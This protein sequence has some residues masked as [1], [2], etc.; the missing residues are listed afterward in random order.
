[1]RHRVTKPKKKKLEELEFAEVLSDT[2]YKEL[3]YDQLAILIQNKTGGRKLGRPVARELFEAIIEMIF[4]Q[5]VGGGYFRFPLG[6]GALKVREFKGADK[7]KVM[8]TR[9][10]LPV[11]PIAQPGDRLHLRYTEGT[12][13][14]QALGTYSL[15]YKRKTE[16]RSRVDLSGVVVLDAPPV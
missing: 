15:P 8:P 12:S 13:V 4:K 11:A 7:P 5:A 2:E 14:R 16:R 6:Y 9:D 10:D 1:M 3:M